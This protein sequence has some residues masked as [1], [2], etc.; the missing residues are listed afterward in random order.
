MIDLVFNSLGSK[1]KWAVVQ[2]GTL[3]ADIQL[4]MTPVKLVII[5]YYYI[6]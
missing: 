2:M 4:N 5:R 1:A 3:Q 6:M